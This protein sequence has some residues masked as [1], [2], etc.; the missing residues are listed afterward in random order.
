VLAGQR[1]LVTGA[2][3]QL[4]RYLIPAIAA[5]GATPVALGHRDGPD[6]DVAVDIA[7]AAAV[8][9][10]IIA[11][12]PDAVIHAAAMTD[13]DGCEKD[14]ERAD[15]VNRL[16]S[17]IVARAAAQAGAWL[18]AVS[19]DFVFPG[20]NPPYAEDALTDPISVYGASKLAGEEAVLTA[21]KSF[22][23]ARTAWVYGG[24]GK[25]FPRTALN[26]L[27]SRETIEV[28]EDER[29]NP[30]FAGDLAEALVALVAHRPNGILHLTNGG[31][32]SRYEL[33]R[34]VA[35]LAGLDPERVK[36]TTV[37]SFLKQYPLPAKRPGDSSLLNRRAAA[38]GITLRSW[39]EALA[40]YMPT[41]VAEMVTARANT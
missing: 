9:D 2:G 14:P 12:R 15:R 3:G 31:T 11:A 22:A 18:V 24:R 41:L 35:S 4:G 26:L 8:D 7:D 17:Q 40:S 37:E 30:T 32:T 20:T 39:Q 5:A 36:P 34:E 6:I 29:G 33:A 13:V 19:T 23:V 10:A 16:G 27:A 1:V 28:V 38:H 21:S 25:H